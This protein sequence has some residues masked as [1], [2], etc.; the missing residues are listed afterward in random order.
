[1][2]RKKI[3]FDALM[4]DK[5]AKFYMTFLM[6]RGG[7]GKVD[8]PTFSLLDTITDRWRSV[9]FRLYCLFPN[10]IERVGYWI[11]DLHRGFHATVT[12][13]TKESVAQNLS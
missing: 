1:M 7:G 3:G 6:S 13:Q 10:V 11:A 5:L 9:N 8:K 4:S 12:Q 2:C